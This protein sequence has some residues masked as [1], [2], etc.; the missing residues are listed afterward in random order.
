MA[1]ASMASLVLAS[2]GA[3]ERHAVW[4]R[5]H[6]VCKLKDE[7]APGH[8]GDG[9]APAVRHVGTASEMQRLHQEC[10]EDCNLRCHVLPP[11]RLEGGEGME[12]HAQEQAEVKACRTAIT[13]PIFE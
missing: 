12:D 5:G 2:C 10:Q 7:P 9:P 6:G 13:A 8:P 1:A 4:D 11:G 3:D